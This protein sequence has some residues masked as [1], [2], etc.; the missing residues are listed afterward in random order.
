MGEDDA[1]CV[2][3]VGLLGV[4]HTNVSLSPLLFRYVFIVSGNNI[5]Y[6]KS[7]F[8]SIWLFMLRFQF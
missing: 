1:Y 3:C 6:L 8:P 5:F 7:F 4:L 2:T